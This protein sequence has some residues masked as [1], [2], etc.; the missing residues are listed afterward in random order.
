MIKTKDEK[1]K[2]SAHNV[3]YGNEWK[4]HGESI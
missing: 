1:E 4:I 3:C 2:E